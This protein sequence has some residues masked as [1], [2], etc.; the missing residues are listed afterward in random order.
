MKNVR[1]R[2]PIVTIA[3][4]AIALYGFGQWTARQGVE[5]QGIIRGAQHSLAIGKAWRAR[6]A[7]LAAIAAAAVQ[8]GRDW[9]AKAIAAAPAGAQLEAALAAATT[10]QDTN[11][12]RLHQ[13]EFYQDQALAWEQS[14]R[15]FENAWR[16]DSARAASAE[17]RVAELE[18]HLAGVLTVADCHILGASFLPRCPSR[19]VAFVLGAGAAAA[20]ILATRH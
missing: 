20:G 10:A 7:K 2:V 5:D 19:N 3:L 13:V 17:A 1:L 14:S 8:T 15:A 11:V 9:K 12:A 4:A 6:Q 16:A 18:R